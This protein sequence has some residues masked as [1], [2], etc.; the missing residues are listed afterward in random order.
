VTSRCG[1]RVSPSR[2]QFKDVTNILL[3]LRLNEVYEDLSPGIDTS[4]A[5]FAGDGNAFLCW[6]RTWNEQMQSRLKCFRYHRPLLRVSIDYE[7]RDLARA[8]GT[9]C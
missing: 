6:L 4:N 9:I 1:D 5:I 2:L 3:S 7:N 8:G